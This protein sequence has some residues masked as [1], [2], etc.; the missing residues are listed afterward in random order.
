M[1]DNAQSAELYP[2]SPSGGQMNADRPPFTRWAVREI[3]VRQR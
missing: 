2:P 1:D 3:R